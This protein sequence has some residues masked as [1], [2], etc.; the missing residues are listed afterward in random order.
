MPAPHTL[1]ITRFSTLT[2][3]PVIWWGKQ[4]ADPPINQK[5]MVAEASRFL[6]SP[7]MAEKV[8]K[9]FKEWIRS[10]IERDGQP[11]VPL[12]NGSL[13]Q[14]MLDTTTS[15]DVSVH[16]DLGS[17]SGELSNTGIEQN[18]SSAASLCI[19]VLFFVLFFVF[20]FFFFLFNS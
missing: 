5:P 9:A 7:E 12:T 2:I 16:F 3:R 1:P 14:L 6:E 17:V 10:Q 8:K 20:F 18:E 19:L 13:V 11:R 4:R 15:L